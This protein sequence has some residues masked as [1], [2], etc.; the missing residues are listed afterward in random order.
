[1][2]P[3]PAYTLS[4]GLERREE[5]SAFSSMVSRTKRVRTSR[6][7]ILALIRAPDITFAPWSLPKYDFATTNIRYT[8]GTSLIA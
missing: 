7:T 5:R 4:V 1:M 3:N 8:D 6:V 2:S